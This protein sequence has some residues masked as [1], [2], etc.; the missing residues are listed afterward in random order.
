MSLPSSSQYAQYSTESTL[1]L[2]RN[3]VKLKT[4]QLTNAHQMP[5]EPLERLLLL[6]KI[7]DGVAVPLLNP[8]PIEM[9]TKIILHLMPNLR[10]GQSYSA[11]SSKTNGFKSAHLY[12]HAACIGQVGELA[13]LLGTS[14]EILRLVLAHPV[15]FPLLWAGCMPYG[16]VTIDACPNPEVGNE[17][18]QSSRL[19]LTKGKDPILFTGHTSIPRS[20]SGVTSSMTYFLAHTLYGHALTGSVLHNM[21]VMPNGQVV[22]IWTGAGVGL[23]IIG[24]HLNNIVALHDE[25]GIWPAMVRNL[26]ELL[27]DRALFGELMKAIE[28]S[29]DKKI[30]VPELVSMLNAAFEARQQHRSPGYA[31]GAS[32]NQ[33][34]GAPVRTLS[35]LWGGAA[36]KVKGEWEESFPP[37]E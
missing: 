34:G 37:K 13:D 17:L 36:T 4:Y 31:I 16:G 11:F 29:H 6:P 14:E 24:G 19:I 23:P 12:V 1:T 5:M 2:A 10:T 32:L 28:G 15:T 25:H 18:I 3:L 30:N 7:F 8:P 20:P 33:Y 27:K 26:R 9:M 21:L 35:T 22:L